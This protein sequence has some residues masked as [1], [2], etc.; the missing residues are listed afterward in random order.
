DLACV[1]A[2]LTLEGGDIHLLDI[3][4]RMPF[5]YGIATMTQSPQAFVRV[6]LTVDG[7]PLHGAAADGL[8]PKWFTKDPHKPIED[9]VEEMLGVIERALSHARDLKAETPFEAWRQL[10][11][12]QDAWGRREWLAP[13]LV[14]LGT[15]LVERAMIDGFCRAIGQPFVNAL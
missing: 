7:Q 3:R 10:Y 13:L 15:S 2:M 11:A 14:H 8:P 6:W 1:V 12:A 5:K 9:E 4:T